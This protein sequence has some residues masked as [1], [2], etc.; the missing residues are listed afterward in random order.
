MSSTKVRHIGIRVKAVDKE[1]IEF[2]EKFGFSR[3]SANGVRINGRHVTW[4][5]MIHADG[6]V[7]ELI[8]GGLTHLAIEVEEVDRNAYYYV[9]PTGHK[10]QY[11]VDPSGNPIELVEEPK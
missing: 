9:T 1:H 6:T 10:V 2:Y 7:L 3:W 11:I 4:C 5:K 8:D